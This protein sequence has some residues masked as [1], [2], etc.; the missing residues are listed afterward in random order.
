M[1]VLQYLL[2]YYDI[3]FIV[4]RIKEYFDDNWNV[5]CQFGMYVLLGDSYQDVQ[6]IIMVIL[7]MV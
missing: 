4:E 7:I 5:K 6:K 3:C 2:N 1:D